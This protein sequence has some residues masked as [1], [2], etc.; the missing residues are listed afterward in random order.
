MTETREPTLNG[1]SLADFQKAVEQLT[2]FEDGDCACCPYWD[3][4]IFNKTMDVAIIATSAVANH[5][6]TGKEL[7][8]E[9]R[10]A[11]LLSFHEIIDGGDRLMWLEILGVKTLLVPTSPYDDNRPD[12]F[13]VSFQSGHVQTKGLFGRQWRCWDIKPTECRRSKT[14]WRRVD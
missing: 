6:A 10:E 2:I 4:K 11:R 5:L 1:K 12:A 13:G 9:G 3:E 14:P 7:V 8:V